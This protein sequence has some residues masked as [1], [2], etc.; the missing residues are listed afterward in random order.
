MGAKDDL[1]GNRQE[2]D[3]WRED[4]EGSAMLLSFFLTPVFIVLPVMLGLGH[5][6]EPYLGPA[7][8]WLTGGSHWLGKTIAIVMI[9]LM[10]VGIIVVPGWLIP[11]WVKKWWDRHYTLAQ[12]MLSEHDL[13][14]LLLS[15]TFIERIFDYLNRSRWQKLA[16][17]HRPVT[18]KQKI[19]FASDYWRALFWIARGRERG[20]GRQVA[21]GNLVRLLDDIAPLAFNG[22]AGILVMAFSGPFVIIVAPLWILLVGWGIQQQAAQAAL[23]DY[24]SEDD[25]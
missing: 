17:T 14:L 11:L 12:R 24:F 3:S 5:L 2:L 18:L 9:I 22:C 10:V 8:D 6:L 19:E 23:L 25:A 4:I 21:W 7:E 16:A 1:Q 15:E 13:A 20:L